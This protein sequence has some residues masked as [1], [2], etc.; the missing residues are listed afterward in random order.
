MSMSTIPSVERR[1]IV[2]V[3]SLRMNRDK[4]EHSTGIQWKN[5]KDRKIAC[6]CEISRGWKNP[7]YTSRQKRRTRTKRVSPKEEIGR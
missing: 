7:D 2:C 1:L 5:T 3:I 6:V 4:F